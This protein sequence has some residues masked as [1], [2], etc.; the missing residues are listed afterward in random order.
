[1]G[2][3]AHVPSRGS[4]K[5]PVLL[6]SPASRGRLQSLPDSSFSFQSQLCPISLTLS[7]FLSDPTFVFTLPPFIL[8]LSHTHLPFLTLALLPPSYENTCDY[9]V[10]YKYKSE[11]CL[12]VFSIFIMEVP[13][14]MLWLQ[15]YPLQ[16]CLSWLNTVPA[17]GLDKEPDLNISYSPTPPQTPL[18]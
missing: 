5:E 8:I 16:R 2:R 3:Q 4:S 12:F 18:F 10:L 17:A 6:P 15:R 9:R 14:L 11:S 1:M 13:D 7:P